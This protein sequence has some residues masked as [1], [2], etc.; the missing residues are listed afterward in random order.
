MPSSRCAA[1]DPGITADP[2]SLAYLVYTSGSTGTPKGVEITHANL[3]NLIDWHRRQFAVTAADRASHLAGLGFDAAVWEIWPYLYSGACVTLANELVRSAPPLLR[4]WL[5]DEA[6]TIAF[7]PTPLAEP[8]MAMDWPAD[9][10]LRCL[11]LG[12]WRW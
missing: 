12:L 6:I 11:L 5:L 2:E 3:L 9:A 4:S 8:L 7:V 1:V 10:P